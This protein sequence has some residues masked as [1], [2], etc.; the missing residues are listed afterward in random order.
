MRSRNFA[1][2]TNLFRDTA[3][4][5]HGDLPFKPEVS[6][7]LEDHSQ[8]HLERGFRGGQ[9]ATFV[10][11]DIVKYPQLSHKNCTLLTE[12]LGYALS[13]IAKKIPHT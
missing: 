13:V 6:L 9:N 2:V 5:C 11:V 8:R 3:L 12:L 10:G 1:F 7:R 4:P